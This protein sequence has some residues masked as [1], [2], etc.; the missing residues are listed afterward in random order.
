MGYLSDGVFIQHGGGYGEELQQE[1]FKEYKEIFKRRFGCRW[2]E[3]RDRTWVDSELRDRML[4]EAGK[5]VQRRR[6]QQHG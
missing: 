2:K 5:I 4:T 6:R 1:I 3:W